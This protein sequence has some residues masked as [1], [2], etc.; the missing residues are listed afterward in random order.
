MLAGFAHPHFF[1][2]A[3]TQRANVQP[4]TTLTRADNPAFPRRVAVPRTDRVRNGRLRPLCACAG[5]GRSWQTLQESECVSRIWFYYKPYAFISTRTVPYGIR[6][7]LN[8]IR[9][10]QA[11]YKRTIERCVSIVYRTACWCTATA[12][13]RLATDA[14]RTPTRQRAP[15]A[16]PRESPRRATRQSPRARGRGRSVRTCVDYEKRF[17]LTRRY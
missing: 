11:R 4:D 15:V 10:V 8:C 2:A 13:T 5:L 6:Y 9:G 7:S 12:H 17:G 14:A 16:V 3:C 1:V